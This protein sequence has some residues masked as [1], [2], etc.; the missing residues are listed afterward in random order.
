MESL[1][2]FFRYLLQIVGFFFYLFLG[3]LI[4]ALAIL[5]KVSAIILADKYLYNI[6][7]LGDLLRGIEIIELLNILV[8]AMLGMVLGIG[9][10]LLPRKIGRKV[11]AI[12]LIVLVPIVF[13]TT[14]ISRYYLWLE[15]VGADSGL[16]LEQT[17]VIGNSFFLKKVGVPGF[18]GF[19]LYTG[20]FPVLPAKKSEMMEMERLE[21]SVNSR[22]VRLTGI[23]PTVINWLMILCFWLIRI[24]YFL[25]A[26]FATIN[27]FH[28]GLRFAKR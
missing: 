12:L 20:K 13:I 25:I 10:A 28:Q 5:F 22:F 19:Y 8:F 23:P 1:H 7:F 24:F 17:E 27:H 21:K 6:L 3:A 26:I 4:V 9:A 18:L 11:S 15:K 14:P 2:P 16:E